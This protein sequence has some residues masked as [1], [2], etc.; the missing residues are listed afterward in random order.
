MLLAHR[1]PQVRHSTAG[2]LVCTPEASTVWG[3]EQLQSIAEGRCMRAVL[4]RK[5][6]M[7]L[8]ICILLCIWFCWWFQ[9]TLTCTS[10]QILFTRV[11]FI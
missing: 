3:S 5:A 2:C 1:A 6:R 4:G 11:H 10:Q 9:S 7:L 8:H